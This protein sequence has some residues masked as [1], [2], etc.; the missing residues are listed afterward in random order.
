LFV[1]T[2]V[3][4]ANNWSCGASAAN[5]PLISKICAAISLLPF[6]LPFPFAVETDGKTISQTGEDMIDK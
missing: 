4:W 3:S 6:P 5:T 1:N 2:I